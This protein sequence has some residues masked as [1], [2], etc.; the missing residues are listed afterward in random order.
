M[1]ILILEDEAAIREVESAYLG[2]AG[3]EVLEFSNGLDALKALPKEHVDL[4]ILDIN[5]PGLSGLE[6]CRRLR[7]H[8][9]APIILVTAKNSDLDE[10][11]GLEYGADD[12]L[13][14]PFNPDILVARVNALLRRHAGKVVKVGDL[15][16]EPAAQ[17]LS[18]KGESIELSAIQFGI[19]YLLTSQPGRVFSRG[20]I[21]DQ[22]YGD[23]F[24]VSV[25]ERTVDAHIT[26]LR[27][28]IEEDPSHPHYILTSVGRGYRCN[29]H[30]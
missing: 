26:R 29:P 18:K 23:P 3:F 13:K 7:R 2:R 14:K 6:V 21:V 28:R 27:K 15:L 22:V 9:L 8:T 17:S 5:V 10:L 24:D 1:R 12:Y 30:A 25:L 19:L 16:L 20:E 11:K 4:F